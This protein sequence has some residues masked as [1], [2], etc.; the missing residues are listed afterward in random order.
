MV[1]MLISEFNKSGASGD[2]DTWRP[3]EALL[4]L[5]AA[6]LD[7]APGTDPRWRRSEGDLPALVASGSVIIQTHLEEKRR[8]HQRLTAFISAAGLSA[9]LGGVPREEKQLS[10][11]GLLQTNAERL[12]LAVALRGLQA[13]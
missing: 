1:R 5:S 7:E 3:D 11:T 8:V 6:I 4:S 9:N 12:E 13:R 2:A 10:T